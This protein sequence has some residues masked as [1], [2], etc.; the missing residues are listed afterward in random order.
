MIALTS[1]SLVKRVK[2]EPYYWTLPR[3]YKITN[4]YDFFDFELQTPNATAG[5]NLK[6]ELYIECEGSYLYETV[7]TF[8]LTLCI[9]WIPIHPL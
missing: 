1:F 2:A 5:V 7:V 3:Q 4:G 9:K 8:I 6:L